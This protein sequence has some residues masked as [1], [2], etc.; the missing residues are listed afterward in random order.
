MF[1]HLFSNTR[2]PSVCVR[3][4]CYVTVLPKYGLFFPQG[5]YFI[6]FFRFRRIQAAANLLIKQLISQPQ[7][8]C[9]R[10]L[11]FKLFVPAFVITLAPSAFFT[12]RQITSAPLTCFTVR[13]IT[14]KTKDLSWSQS[15]SMLG[16]SLLKAFLFS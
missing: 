8:C 15:W 10:F 13:Q 3:Q 6:L 1:T 9:P 4:K 5:G 11:I 2:I 12:V 14:K 7:L 16:R